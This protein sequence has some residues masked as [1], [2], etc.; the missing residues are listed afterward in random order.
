ME[1]RRK[2]PRCRKQVADSRRFCESPDNYRSMMQPRFP[3]SASLQPA[4]EPFRRVARTLRGRPPFPG[5]TF[6]DGFGRLRLTQAR[7]SSCLGIPPGF[8]GLHAPEGRSRRRDCMIPPLGTG[9]EQTEGIPSPGEEM[10]RCP[11]RLTSSRALSMFPL[12][13]E[14]TVLLVCI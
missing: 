9:A 2:A 6:Q 10:W 3:V 11:E 13:Y 1:V 14:S 12:R 5:A 7:H 4:S 8:V